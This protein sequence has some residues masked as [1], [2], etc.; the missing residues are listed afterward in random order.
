MPANYEEGTFE[1]CDA[2]DDIPMGV[3]GTSTWYQGVSPTPP[4]QPPASSSNCISVPTVSATPEKMRRRA[5]PA[6]F[7]RHAAP[8]PTNM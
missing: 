3:Y 6:D 4:A 8:A 5:A 1:N 2:D 7:R